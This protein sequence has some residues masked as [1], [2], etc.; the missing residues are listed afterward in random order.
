MVEV[1]AIAKAAAVVVIVVVLVVVIRRVRV[2]VA[3]VLV[4]WTLAVTKSTVQ[5]SY[6]VI[7]N[8]LLQTRFC[9]TCNDV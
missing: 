6:F 8:G 7:T 9:V 3:V 1:V 2:V 5:S 4:Q